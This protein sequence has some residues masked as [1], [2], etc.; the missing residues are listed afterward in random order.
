MR[1]VTLVVRNSK[2][3]S[4]DGGSTVENRANVVDHLVELRTGRYRSNNSKMR[5]YSSAHDEGLTNE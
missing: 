3:G 1:E 5:R 4:Y 2:H